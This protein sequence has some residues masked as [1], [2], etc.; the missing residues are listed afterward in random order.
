MFLSDYASA[1]NVQALDGERRLWIS[2]PERMQRPNLPNQL[3]R[4]LVQSNF[5]VDMQHGNTL[6]ISDPCLGNGGKSL[7]KF[8]QPRLLNRNSGRARMTTECY[9]EVST[10]C[11]GLIQVETWH[12]PSRPFSDTVLIHCDDD[13]R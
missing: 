4:D 2:G 1:E 6:S 3:Q 12:G 8:R 9:E 5:R 7:R 13:R 11:Q 10:G